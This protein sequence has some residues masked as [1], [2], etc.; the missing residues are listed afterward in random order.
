MPVAAIHPTDLIIG[1]GL[2]SAEAIAQ[3]LRE[4]LVREL[5][6]R[7]SRIAPS[8]GELLELARSILQE[9]EPLLA[10]NL[11]ATD[12]AAWIAG[13]D[14]VAAKLPKFALEDFQAGSFGP[15]GPPRF[16][17]PAGFD[18]EWREPL[19]R[20]PLIERAAESL[21]NRR[22]VTPEQFAQLSDQEKARAF[23]IAGEMS[24]DTLATIRDVLLEDVREGT[25]LAEFSRVLEER[26]GGSPI[27]PA[28]LETVYRTNV[29][30][31]FSDGHEDLANNPIVA[32]VFPYQEYLAVH[33]ARARHD[34]LALESL[35][36]DGTGIYRRDD[37]FWGYFTPPWGFN[38]RCGV[39]LLTLKAAA[40]KGVREAQAWLE[41][42]R[43]PVVPEWR[44]SSIPF[45]PPAGFGG[46][47]KRMVA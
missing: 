39:N 27:G 24:L 8:V 44:L 31:A 34:H 13:T 32:A 2:I 17:F 4:R 9:F 22:I 41:T 19:V 18:D 28:H 42:G 5:A 20:F 46:R 37:P 7:K 43:A 25:S 36:L 3:E 40:R 26:I 14:R 15:P 1:R 47:V 6:R 11:R 10:E 33:D 45:R 16:T 12:L 30:A 35:G 29:Q 23:S 21:A 38:C